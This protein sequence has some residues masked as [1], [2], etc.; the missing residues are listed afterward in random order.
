M[1]AESLARSPSSIAWVRG[2]S[3]NSAT[4]SLR[5]ALAMRAAARTMRGL[6]GAG[7]MQTKMR[8]LV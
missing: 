8:S 2:L 4:N 6:V 7:E 5:N 3:T 1:L